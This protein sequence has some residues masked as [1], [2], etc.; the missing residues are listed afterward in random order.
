ME[1]IISIKG[2]LEK[3][4]LALETIFSKICLAYENENTR[5]WNYSSQYYQQQQLMQNF[6]QHAAMIAT[7]GANG[8]TFLPTHYSQQQPLMIHQ[9]QTSN[10]S[11][12][13]YI[14][15]QPNLNAIYPPTYYVSCY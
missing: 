12:N 6:A 8:Q 15:Q 9:T 11:P 5:A 10:S 4:I 1:R 7:V 13:K 2:E 14:E 3:Q